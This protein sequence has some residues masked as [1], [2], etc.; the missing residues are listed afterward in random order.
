MHWT[1][2]RVS[3]LLAAVIAL[4][5]VGGAMAGVDDDVNEIVGRQ[6]KIY[7]DAQPIPVYDYSAQRDVIVQ[8]YNATIPKLQNTWSVFYEFG[9]ATDVCQSKGYPIPYG[10]SLTSPEYMK[11][12]GNGGDSATSVDL[13]QPEPSGLYTNGLSTSASWVLCV[14]PTNGLVEPVYAEGNVRTYAHPVSID[15][16]SHLAHTYDGTTIW[17]DM[18]QAGGS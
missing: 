4:T 16:N 18:S 9:T 10:V 12:D 14:N 8:L 15:A 6:N 7:F 5:L 3:A 13:P 11:T 17:M 1:T 2:R